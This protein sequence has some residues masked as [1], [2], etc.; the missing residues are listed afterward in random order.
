MQLPPAQ[1]PF[2]VQLCSWGSVMLEKFEIFRMHACCGGTPKK[3]P[4]KVRTTHTILLNHHCILCHFSN[5]NTQP[6]TCHI[7]QL[8]IVALPLNTTYN[9]HSTTF[10]IQDNYNSAKRFWLLTT[11]IVTTTFF[12]LQRHT[13]MSATTITF[14]IEQYIQ[15]SGRSSILEML[16]IQ[17]YRR[18]LHFFVPLI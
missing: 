16:L 10:H 2:G 8:I 11:W 5:H 6:A 14:L 15:S 7:R 3:Q 17:L 13:E 1:S 18:P 12:E 4:N 9:A